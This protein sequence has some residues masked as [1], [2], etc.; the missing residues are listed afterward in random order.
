MNLNTESVNLPLSNSMAPV[1]SNNLDLRGNNINHNNN[2]V[3]VKT[4]IPVDINSKIPHH[5]RWNCEN[6]QAPEPKPNGGL[7]R[8]PQ[9]TGPHASIPVVPTTTNMIHHNL[10][11]A[12]PPPG[13][14]HQYP[15]TNRDKNNYVPM[16]GV[17][18]YADTHPTNVGP[19][20][21]KIT[22]SSNMV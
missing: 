9:A 14:I 19:H 4:N 13:A 21:I 6:T 3:Q 11:S 15:G 12:N 17:Y 7:F 22:D 10:R 8:G 16:P 20:A 2:L 18:W 1:A 5:L